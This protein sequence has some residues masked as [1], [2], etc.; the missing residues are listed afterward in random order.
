MSCRKILVG[1]NSLPAQM[2]NIAKQISIQI[3]KPS[4]HPDKLDFPWNLKLFCLSGSLMR[5][6]ERGGFRN[7]YLKN[8]KPKHRRTSIFESLNDQLLICI[9]IHT[10]WVSKSSRFNTPICY[11][12]LQATDDLFFSHFRGCPPSHS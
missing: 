3:F 5:G 8:N 10:W 9:H 11:K 12:G 4:V 6:R 2:E 1:A 7:T